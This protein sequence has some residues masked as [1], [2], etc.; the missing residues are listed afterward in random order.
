[1]T[2]NIPEI[3]PEQLPEAGDIDPNPGPELQDPELE[4]WR[5]HDAAERERESQASDKTKFEELREEE[6]DREAAE[7]VADVPSP[8][9]D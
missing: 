5:Q 6:R 9:D 8:R 1:M 4:Q 2:E 7:I 3:E